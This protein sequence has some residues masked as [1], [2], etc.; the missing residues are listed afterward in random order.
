M[1]DWR[2]FDMVGLAIAFWLAFASSVSGQ[3]GSDSEPP[4]SFRTA[5]VHLEAGDTVGA[6]AKLVA[7]TQQAP[8]YGPAFLRLGSLLSARAGELEE[9]WPDRKR[10][11]RALERARELMGDDPEVLLE[12]GLLLR[13]Q[14]LKGDAERALNRA[15]KAAEEESE[16]L[17]P[18]RL[19]ELYYT[20]GS[21]YE[22]WWEDW[23]NLVT[24]PSSVAPLGCSNVRQ[25]DDEES[26]VRGRY[27]H[28]D[29]AVLCPGR[30]AE[31]YDQVVWLE[32]LRS[33]ERERMVEYY[34][35]A[36][37]ADSSRIDA[38]YRLLGHLADAGEWDEY[39]EVAEQL[40]R[41]AAGNARA[42]LLLALGLHETGREGEAEAAFARA[43][44]LL[45]PR[46]RSVF[47]DVAPLLKRSGRELY[48]E[49]DSAG[50]A[51]ANRLFFTSTDPLYLSEASERRLEHY[52]RVAWAELKFGDPSTGERGWDSERGR[53][54][55]RYGPPWRQYQCCYGGI[56]DQSIGRYRGGRREYWSYGKLGPVFVFERHLTY[57]HASHTAL[58]KFVADDLA[59][60][61]PQ[62][63]QPRA[64][65]AIHEYPHQL[66]RFRGAEPEYSRLEIYSAPPVALL[67]ADTGAS[68]ETGAFLFDRSFH[69]LWSRRLSAPVGERAVAL[70]YEVEVPAGRYN[71]ALEARRES[72]ANEPRPVAR[73]RD[74]LTVAGFPE[75]RLSISDILL[76]DALRPLRERPERRE[77]LRIWPNR[78]LRVGVD[79]PV[80][81]YFE[82]YGLQTDAD[83][84]ARYRVELAVEDAEQ[85]NVVERIARGVTELF[86]RGGEREPQVSWE[87]TVVLE[88][89]R[90]MEY[91]T[92]DLRSL[93]PGARKVRVTITDLLVGTTATMERQFVVEE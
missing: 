19:A 63:Y 3:S 11:Q 48:S 49:L 24:I 16:R 93:E 53:I 26:R 75:G 28:A 61:H 1:F 78:T 45:P 44:S 76:A 69:E 40:T 12:L 47:T 59:V 46:E 67:D 4:P 92:V 42:H 89:D 36:F 13:R 87:R 6:I 90:S 21:I 83:G 64:I 8:D 68:L 86:R 71:Y 85:R 65:A 38:G 52:S 41:I 5:T 32:D 51:E 82:V 7:A 43:L 72:E 54:W 56:L 81:L 62:L 35:R 74:S 73:M 33:D 31:Q 14:Q 25:P 80:S 17:G 60:E 55:I 70:S 34:R 84:L 39:N 37:R 2:R 22:S 10:A 15:W 23:R 58:S 88:G 91:V 57:R 30:W 29:L 66:V 77:E 50:R 18:E 20:L 79:E 27:D 9:N